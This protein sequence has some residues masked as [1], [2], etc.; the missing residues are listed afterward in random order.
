[1][2]GLAGGFRWRVSMEGLPGGSP[3]RV[4]MEGLHGG[5]PWRVSMEGLDYLK[6][7]PLVAHSWG[8]VQ[9]DTNAFFFGTSR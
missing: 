3:W 8:P 1:M 2:E 7:C 4:S 6:V 5:S 9:H